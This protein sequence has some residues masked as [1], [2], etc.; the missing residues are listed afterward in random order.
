MSI[1]EAGDSAILYADVV[2][3]HIEPHPEGVPGHVKLR[4]VV[5]DKALTVLWLAPAGAVERL[6]I[7]LA[8]GAISENMTYRGGTVAGYN[9]SK[10]GGCACGQS[11]L[12][13][14]KPWPGVTIVNHV[15]RSPQ[16]YGVPP[17][18]YTRV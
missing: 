13:G 9:I 15:R 1:Y 5:T 7:P 3:A 14:Y 10:N 11:R 4:A 6:D 2:P 18:R 16:I 17:T 12:L 8:E